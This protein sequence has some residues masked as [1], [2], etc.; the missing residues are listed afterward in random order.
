[1]ANKKLTDVATS[2]SLDTFFVKSSNSV[3]Q[4]TPAN[5][6]KMLPEA[7]KSAAGIMTATQ[8]TDLENLK[9]TLN[10]YLTDVASLVGGDA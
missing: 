8:V 4:I 6:V 3:R 10:S 9:T 1:M 7:T 5:A 2:T